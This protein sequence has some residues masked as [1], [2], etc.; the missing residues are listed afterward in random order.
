MVYHMKTTVNISETVM[1]DLKQEAA[2]RGKTMSELIECALRESLARRRSPSAGV[3]L[4]TF[5]GGKPQVDI[6]NRDILY[7]AMED[8]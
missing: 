3:S 2:R 5:R 8:R 7:E 6:A 4:P 1:R